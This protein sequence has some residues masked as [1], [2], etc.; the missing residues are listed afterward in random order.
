[1]FFVFF[2]CYAVFVVA[3]V[4]GVV[5]EYHHSAYEKHEKIYGR[6]K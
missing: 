3:D 4:T 5:A 2:V 6:G 1:M